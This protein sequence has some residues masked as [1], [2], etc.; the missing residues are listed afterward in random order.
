MNPDAIIKN[1]NP[2]FLGKILKDGYAIIDKYNAPR[3]SDSSF[4]IIAIPLIKDKSLNHLTIRD[5]LKSINFVTSKVAEIDKKATRK[6]FEPNGLKEYT[7]LSLDQCFIKILTEYSNSISAKPEYK[8]IDMSEEQLTK[9]QIKSEVIGSFVN[10]NKHFANYGV[11]GSFYAFVNFY[12]VNC[13]L[14]PHIKG[15]ASDAEHLK[16][17]C[18]HVY[19]QCLKEHGRV[20]GK[21][22]NLSYIQKALSEKKALRNEKEEKERNE[23]SECKKGIWMYTVIQHI[24]LE[25]IQQTK[26]FKQYLKEQYE[27]RKGKEKEQSLIQ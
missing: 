14:Y 18:R 24:G 6:G 16:N 1:C 7:K 23:N 26:E 4:E 12:I 15:M 11:Q 9:E 8:A 19:N 3:L 22:N 20:K 21:D 17:I 25:E 27:Q 10:T 5:L 2:S 13:Q